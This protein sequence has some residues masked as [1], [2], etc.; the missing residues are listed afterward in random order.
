[1][2]KNIYPLILLVILL[3]ATP[4]FATEKA[5]ITVKESTVN[6][7]VVIV[8]IRESGKSYELQCNQTASN[9]KVLKPADYWMVRLP[10]NYGLYDCANVDL[11]PQSANPDGHDQALGEY[12]IN[13]K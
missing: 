2:K 6:N 5:L 3:V 9:C 8:T 1:M 10:K 11:Y 13:E 12:C 4:L 7:G